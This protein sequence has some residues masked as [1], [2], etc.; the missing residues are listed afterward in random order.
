MTFAKSN[1]K[2][3]LKSLPI[4]VKI[5]RSIWRLCNLTPAVL[6][7]KNYFPRLF[8]KHP[9]AKSLSFAKGIVKGNFRETS[10]VLSIRPQN[11][12]ES[13]V[14]LNGNWEPNIAELIASYLHGP[15]VAVIDVGANIGA[16]SIPLAKHFTDVK[17]F[18]FEPHP[19]IFK[20]LRNNISFNKLSNIESYNIAITDQVDSLLPFY[21]QTNANNFGLSSFTL[22]HDIEDYEVIQVECKSL[23]AMFNTELQ[24]KVLKIDTQGHELNVL[25]SAKQLISKHRPIIFFEFESEY[26][27]NTD[28]EIEAREKLLN[29]FEQLHYELYMLEN[30]SD[31][32]PKLTLKDYFHGDILAVPLH[33]NVL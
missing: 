23:D 32:F 16:T 29:F 9:N 11:F 12:I 6:S 2:K 7:D 22:N 26:F 20:D 5:K 17:F 27:R 1:L 19:I 33:N 14:F 21:A 25:L 18:L 15:N 30:D 10:F 8:S 3:F 4:L 24:L 28:S 13:S 31:F